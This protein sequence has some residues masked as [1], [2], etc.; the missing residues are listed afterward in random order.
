MAQWITNLTRNLEVEGSIPGLAHWAVVYV[1]DV[2]QILSCCGSGVGPP[3][4]GTSVC[5]ECDPIKPKKKK[6]E[7]Q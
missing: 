3:S 4:L 5:C 1:A 6:K 2:A 7:R